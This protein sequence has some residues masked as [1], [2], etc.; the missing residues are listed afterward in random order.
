MVERGEDSARFLLS[1][2]HCADQGS[3]WTLR[4]ALQRVA[5]EGMGGQWGGGG[6]EVCLVLGILGLK[7]QISTGEVSGFKGSTVPHTASMH[8]SIW[9]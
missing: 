5:T 1:R 6:G 4:M 9:D 3:V 7:P 2:P 8:P